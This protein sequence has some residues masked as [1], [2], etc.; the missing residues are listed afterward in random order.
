VYKGAVYPAVDG[1]LLMLQSF[2]LFVQFLKL[3][4]D[5]MF[6]G[7]RSLCGATGMVMV[8]HLILLLLL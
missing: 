4:T 7:R 1:F 2:L 5:E 6:T 3:N 8:H